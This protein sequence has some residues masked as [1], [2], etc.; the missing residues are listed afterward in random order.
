[1]RKSRKYDDWWTSCPEESN[2][3]CDGDQR[4]KCDEAQRCLGEDKIDE[5]DL[6]ENAIFASRYEHSICQRVSVILRWAVKE[7]K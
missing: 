3:F 4:R 7:E 2:E 1:M 5:D 6:G